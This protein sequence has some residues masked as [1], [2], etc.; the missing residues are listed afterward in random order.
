MTVAKALGLQADVYAAV[1][2]AVASFG[3]PVFD[4]APTDPPDEF[5]RLDAFDTANITSKR[6]E[7]ARHAFEVHHFVSPRAGDTFTRGQTRA[8]TVLAAAHAGVMAAAL[9]GTT[10]E[11]EYF[12]VD[13]DI[14]GVTSHGMSR[15]TVVLV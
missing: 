11:H 8:K 10:A 5:I 9:Q 13:T 2:A 4:H 1:T 7:M 15:Y 12:H 3:I 14:D 6:G